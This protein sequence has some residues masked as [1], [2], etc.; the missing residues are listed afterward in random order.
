VVTFCENFGLERV[1][2][3][4]KWPKKVTKWPLLKT[5]MATTNGFPTWFAGFLVKN[6]LLFSFNCDKKFK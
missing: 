2:K 5:K 1:E 3:V 4:V 6:P